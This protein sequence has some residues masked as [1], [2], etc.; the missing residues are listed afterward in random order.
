MRELKEQNKFKRILGLD[1]GTKRIGIAISD[2]LEISAQPLKAV[3]RKPDL[4]SINEIKKIC[5]EYNV[6]IIVAG[7]PKNMNGSIGF[8]AEDVISYLELLKKE[9]PLTIELEDERLTSVI[10]EKALIEQ[11]KK[12]SKKKELIDISSAILIL[13]QFLNKRR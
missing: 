3:S 8:Q 6:F 11:N 12:P 13:Q 2:P 9:I 7:L 4:D 1:I 5:E 10:A